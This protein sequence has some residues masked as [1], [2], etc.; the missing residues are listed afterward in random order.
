MSRFITKRVLAWLRRR[1]YSVTQVERLVAESNFR[2]GDI[3][4]DG[5][6]LEVRLKKS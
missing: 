5:I 1:A 2:N 6:G 3:K 4:A